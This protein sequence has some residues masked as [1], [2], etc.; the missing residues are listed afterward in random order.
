MG[1]DFRNIKAWQFADRL[2]LAIYQITQKFPSHEL[3]GVVSQLRRASVSVPSNIAEGATRN[4][5][6]EFIQFLF[7]AKGSLAEVEYFLHLSKNL[8]YISDADYVILDGVRTECAKI[9]HGLVTS[10]SNAK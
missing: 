2:T 1:R 6:K 8:G 4:S 10:I 3:Y 9:L 7:I 5:T